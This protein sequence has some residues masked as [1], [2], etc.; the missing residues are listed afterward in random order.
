MRAAHEGRQAEFMTFAQS[1]PEK[2]RSK[3]MAND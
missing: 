1:E 3:K 2:K